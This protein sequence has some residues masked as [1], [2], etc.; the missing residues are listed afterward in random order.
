MALH[1]PH[2]VAKASTTTTGWAA[3]ASLNWPAVSKMWTVILGVVVVKALGLVT[4]DV[5]V[6]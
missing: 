2:Q 3:T 5:G 6:V 1:G 4:D